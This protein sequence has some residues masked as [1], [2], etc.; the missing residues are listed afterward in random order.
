MMAYWNNDHVIARVVVLRDCGFAKIGEVS[1]AVDSALNRKSGAGP[2][3]G[4]RGGVKPSGRAVPRADGRKS[5]VS[6]D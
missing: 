1:T 2:V 6:E 3:D 5:T 4:A